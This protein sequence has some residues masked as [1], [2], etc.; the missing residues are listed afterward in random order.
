MN[1]NRLDAPAKQAGRNGFI[2][3]VLLYKMNRVSGPKEELSFCFRVGPGR[4]FEEAG[5][6]HQR[7]QT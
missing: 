3:P 1:F 2:T 6:I 5:L 4:V 7:R